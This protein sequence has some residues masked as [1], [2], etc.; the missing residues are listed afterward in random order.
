MTPEEWKKLELELSLPWGRAE[1]QV[2]G[3][4]ITLET[5][6]KGPMTFTIGLFVD[7]W[8]RVEWMMG[9]CDQR[10][11]FLR[12]TKHDAWKKSDR[13][14]LTKGFSKRQIAKF[15]PDIDKKI[16]T[17]SFYWPSVT[18]LRRHLVKNNQV[19]ELVKLGAV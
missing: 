1:L 11:R 3:Y 18:A 6:R 8:M 16:S 7:G 2:D 5:H 13:E 17:W 15:F 19:I 9:D 10:R 14:K 4:K 12:E